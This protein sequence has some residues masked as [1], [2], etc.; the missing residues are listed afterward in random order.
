MFPNMLICKIIK[1]R[2]TD[3]PKDTIVIGIFNAKDD[4]YNIYDLNKDVV[5]LNS[6]EIKLSL[7][8]SIGFTSY[9]KAK[10]IMSTNIGDDIKL[11]ATKITQKNIVIFDDRDI[12]L[13]ILQELLVETLINMNKEIT[14]ISSPPLTFKSKRLYDIFSLPWLNI[15][16]M[17]NNS[18]IFNVFEDKKHGLAELERSTRLDFLNKLYQYIIKI[19]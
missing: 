9:K 15:M 12:Y 6:Y 3:M 10:D 16:R 8:G 13:P 4:K 5:I 2:F 19:T 7:Y 11:F 18:I 17:A 14:C 1:F